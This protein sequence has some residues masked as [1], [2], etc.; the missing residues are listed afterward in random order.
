MQTLGAICH[1]S[2][3]VEQDILRRVSADIKDKKGSALHLRHQHTAVERKAEASSQD[4]LDQE[5]LGLT[6]ADILSL[7]ITGAFFL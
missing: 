5:L 6:A 3:L 7:P 1:G 4:R 2:N